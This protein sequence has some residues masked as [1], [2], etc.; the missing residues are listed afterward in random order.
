MKKEF[1]L[2]IIL[3]N[4]FTIKVNKTTN[5]NSKNRMILSEGGGWRV[6]QILHPLPESWGEGVIVKRLSIVKIVV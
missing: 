2:Y 5:K 1:E 6:I 4:M 3:E